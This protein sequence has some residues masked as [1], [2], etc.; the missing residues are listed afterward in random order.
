MDKWDIL[1]NSLLS[2]FVGLSTPIIT[3][4]LRIDLSAVII[5]NFL[6]ISL[7]WLGSYIK[8]IDKKTNKSLFKAKENEKAIMEIKE[9]LNINNRLNVLEAWKEKMDKKK[10]QINVVDLIKLIAIII[11]GYLILRAFL[12]AAK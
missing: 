6:I 9:D 3:N 5:I 1:I 7:F 12:T 4:I 10:G 8:E 2:I 11:I